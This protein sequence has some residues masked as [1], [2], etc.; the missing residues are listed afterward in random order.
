[1]LIVFIGVMI[2]IASM[3]FP[4]NGTK[5]GQTKPKV[6]VVGLLGPIPFGFGNDA[7]WFQMIA[8]IAFVF[9]LLVWFLRLRMW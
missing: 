6:A 3:F 8:I 9:F 5:E 4:Q 1:M 2:I 7:K